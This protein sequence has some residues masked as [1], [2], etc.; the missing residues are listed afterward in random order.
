MTLLGACAL[1]VLAVSGW[2]GY[3]A[4][5]RW[6]TGW[7]AL[8]QR[9]PVTSVQNPG[10]KY[11]GQTCYFNARQWRSSFSIQRMFSVELAQ[12]GIVVTAYFARQSPLLIPWPEVCAVEDATLFGSE[13]VHVSAYYDKAIAD[14]RYIVRFTVPREALP[15]MMGHV[16]IELLR[17]TDSFSELL[18]DRLKSAWKP[19]AGD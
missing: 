10:Q 9:F 12:E 18:R 3:C 16:P 6:Q 11:P 17:K 1:G 5:L 15:T 8:T 13:I 19:P 2:A 4:L 14:R 7:K